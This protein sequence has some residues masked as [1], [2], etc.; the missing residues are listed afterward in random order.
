MLN[1]SLGMVE[2]VNADRWHEVCRRSADW[3][4]A[5]GWGCVLGGGWT[6]SVAAKLHKKSSSLLAVSAWHVCAHK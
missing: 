5:V 3:H 4:L 1:V 2:Q 6:A